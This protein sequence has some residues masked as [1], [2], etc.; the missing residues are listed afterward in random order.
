MRE[1]LSRLVGFLRGRRLDRDMDDEMRFHLEMATDEYLRRGLNRDD[2]RASAL[3]NFGGVTQMKEAY[4]DQ[5]G[6]PWI[7]ML[8]QDVRYGGRMLLRAPGFTCAALL[9]LALGI[10][11]NTAI[12]SVVNAVLLRPL[13]YP[14]PDRLVQ[15]VRQRSVDAA[16]QTGRRYLF[17]RDHLKSVEALTAYRGAGSLNMARGDAARFVSVRAVSKEYFTVFGAAPALG[18]PFTDEHDVAGGPDV[19]ILSHV[20]WQSAFQGRPD[21]IGA[22]VHVAEKPYTVIGVLPERFETGSAPDMLIPLRPGVT[23]PGGGFNYTVVGRLREGVSPDEASAEVAA[24]WSAF[25][26]EFPNASGDRER[27]SGFVS[28]QESIASTVKPS[29]LMMFGAVGLLLLIACANTANLLLA[30]ASSRGR[31]MAVRAAL[32]AARGRIVR[33]VLTESTLLA[34]V[35][36]MLG[37]ALA[38]WTV[39]ALLALT[40]PAYRVTADVRIDGFVL[41]TTLLLAAATGMLFGIAPA[42]GS[43]RHDVSEAFKED[44]TRTAGSR[45]SGWLR[46]LLVAGEVALCMLLLVGAGLLGRTFLRLRA[47]DPGFDIHGVLTARMSMQGERYTMPEAVTRFYE[48]GLARI[49]RLPGVHSAAVVNGVPLE[50]AL[51]LNV[52]VLDGPEKVENALIDWRY[53][54]TD[55]F[56]TMGIPIVAGRAFDDTDRGGSVPVAV[57][58]EEFARRFFQAGSPLGRHIRVFKD[59]GAIEIV[60]VARNLKEGGLRSRPIPVMYVPVAQTHAAA[61]R[62]THTYFHVSWVVRADHPGAALRRQI[63]EEIRAIDPRQPF[64]AFRTMEETKMQSM[65]VERFQMTLLGTFAVIGLLLAT[66]GIYGLVAYSVNQRA[67]E[68]GIRMAL[69]ASTSSILRSVLGQGIVLAVVG[70]VIGAVAAVFATR[71]LQAFVWEV[72]TLDPATYIVVAAVL[73]AV[74]VI[75]SLVPALRAVRLNPVSA[76]RE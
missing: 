26:A 52:T 47:V 66:A 22:T 33:Q 62:T 64:S 49:R 61:I 21:A 15:L 73:I 30:R 12:F 7:E 23:G 29:L 53:A 51:N 31:E 43:S 58:S 9:T 67:R 69:G 28:L 37:V 45:R 16:G 74:A 40:P 65:A 44:G 17:F 1:A 72:S 4:R 13:P 68:F 50:R 34:L 75:A 27:P 48:E 18:Q 57:V 5:R 63:E 6:L 35:G 14:H 42:L 60:G 46:R 11:A 3:R 59:D 20:L 25:R 56:E 71:V 24:L 76:L 8:L 41:L 38:Y 2:A 54:T 32:G 70:V 39:P 10:G 36:A 55:Y 19:V